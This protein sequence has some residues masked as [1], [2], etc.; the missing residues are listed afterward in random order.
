MA[1]FEQSGYTRD[2]FERLAAL[3]FWGNV[4]T[5]REKL[6]RRRIQAIALTGRRRAAGE[7]VALVRA[8]SRASDLGAAHAVA[9]VFDIL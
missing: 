3:H 1:A 7:D 2:P 8:A 5:F 6:Q 4:L 9:V